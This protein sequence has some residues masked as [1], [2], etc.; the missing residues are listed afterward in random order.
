MH[1]GSVVPAAGRK[2]RFL[3]QLDMQLF[4]LPALVYVLIFSYYPMTGLQIA[5]KDYKFN[6]G[7]WGSQWVGLKH[8][9][10]FFTDIN[11]WPVLR[12]T[13]IL[14]ITKTILLFP[15]PIIFAILLNEMKAPRLKRTIQTISYFPYFISWPIVTLLASYWLSS[16]GLINNLLML[17]GILDKPYFFL[18]EPG[19]F[20]GV[21]IV[22]D[23]WKTLG[24][25]SIIYLAAIATVDVEQ[26][27]AAVIDGAN[28]LTRI[29]HIILPSLLPTI[30][31][32]M[33]MNIGS[34]L[35]GGLYA[36]NF[37]ISYNLANRLNAPTS[38]ILD[39]YILKIGISQG[40]FSYATAIG[41][42]NSVV[43]GVLLLTANYTSKRISGESF[44]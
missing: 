21:S 25:S 33:I 40:R 44:F 37:Q 36:S 22:L 6:Q 16:G 23:V 24:Y 5:F 11:L 28:R 8:F 39:T 17:L 27:E 19:A 38:E 31:I 9:Q 14:S 32:L 29:T 43:S 20:H 42:L 4:V 3:K 7:I 41:L 30:S 10:S 26:L 1:K 13:L 2:P 18:G 12:N 15:L 34:T 35:S